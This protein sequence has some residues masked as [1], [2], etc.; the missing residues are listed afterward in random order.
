MWDFIQTSPTYHDM[1]QNY[2]QKF[3][4]PPS[5]QPIDVAALIENM[6]KPNLDIFFHQSE[7]P[8]LET[9]KK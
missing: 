1:L 4:V 6:N 3:V 8:P 7:L 9:Q 2:L 5:V